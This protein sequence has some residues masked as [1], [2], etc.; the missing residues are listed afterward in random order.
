MQKSVIFIAGLVL[1]MLFGCK[2]KEYDLDMHYDYYPMQRG[3][4]QIYDVIERNYL[5]NGQVNQLNYQLKTVIADTF[6]DNGGKTHYEF[7]RY[8]R[9]TASDEWVFSDL[10]TTYR[11][12]NAQELVEENERMVKLIFP[13][14]KTTTWDANA[15]NL[16]STQNCVYQNLFQPKTFNGLTFDKTVTVL[17][18]EEHNLIMYRKKFEVYAKGVGLVQKHYQHYNI[19]YF[20]TTNI[21]TGKDLYYSIVAHGVQ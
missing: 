21:E 18:E 14:S 3:T 11:N 17:Q 5:S 7:H 8:K 15:Y 13:I 2:K 4:Y 16:Q 9:P 1:V 12:G 10:W 19:S 20:D 6:I